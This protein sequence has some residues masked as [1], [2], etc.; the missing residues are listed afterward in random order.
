[1]GIN[2]EGKGS[3]C[4][5]AQYESMEPGRIWFL[6]R[7]V[8]PAAGRNWA[9]SLHIPLAEVTG[10]HQIMLITKTSSR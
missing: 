10:Q 8:G 9:Q 3:A 2:N 5:I 4:T 1:M 7:G 6:K